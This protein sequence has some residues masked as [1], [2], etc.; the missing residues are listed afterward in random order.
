MSEQAS[1]CAQWHVF[2]LEINLKILPSIRE[3]PNHF[4]QQCVVSLGCSTRPVAAT[5]HEAETWSGLEDTGRTPQVFMA[6][7]CCGID[8]SVWTC[9]FSSEKL[10][11]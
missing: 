11:E 3:T 6:G 8:T 1:L 5:F 7:V 10:S 4:L 9:P 2:L